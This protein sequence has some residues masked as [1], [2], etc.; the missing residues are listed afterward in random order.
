MDAPHTAIIFAGGGGFVPF[1]IAFVPAMIIGLI[2]QWWVKSSFKKYAEVR[3]TSGRTGAEIA[4]MILDRNG[5]TDVVVQPTPGYMT[6]HY[7]PRT[8]TVNLSEPVFAASTI[9]SVSVAA[10]EVGHAIQHSRAYVPMTIRSTIAPAAA[11]GSNMWQIIL[12]AGM[13]LA[14]VSR[15]TGGTLGLHIMEFALILFSAV[16]IFQIVTLPVEF[17]ASRRAKKQ[18]NE[19]G[20]IPHGEAAGT[21]TVLHAAASTYVAAALASVAMLLYYVWMIFGARR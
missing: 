4:R 17:D 10:H 2:A 13:L 19:L 7:D 18:L 5:L 1:L 14:Y 9:S 20:I 12:F 21:A 16:V 15:G 3:S 8:R 11:L 6:D